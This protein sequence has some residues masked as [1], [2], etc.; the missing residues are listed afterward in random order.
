MFAAILPE[1]I[2]MLRTILYIEASNTNAQRSVAFSSIVVIIK[3]M[4]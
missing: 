3:S 2:S 4:A 1:W